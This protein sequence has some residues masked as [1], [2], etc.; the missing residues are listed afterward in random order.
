[1]A[2]DGHRLVGGVLPLD[3]VDSG[4][5]DLAGRLAELV[6]RVDVAVR[7][8]AGARPLAA[9]ADAIADAADALTA[10]AD[11]DAWQRAQLAGLLADV[12]TDE[13]TGRGPAAAGIALDLEEVRA[14]LADRL[15]GRP[16]RANFRTGHLTMCTLVPMRSVPHRVVCLLGLDDGAFPR[17]TAPDGDDVI[18]RAPCVGDHDPRSED[19]QLL[20]DAVLAATETVIVTYSGRDERTNE[21]RP[22]AVPLGE[23]L[24]VIDATVRADDGGPPAAPAASCNSTRCSPSTGRNFTAGALGPARPWSFDRIALAGA[25]AA[26]RPRVP[27]PPLLTGRLPPAPAEIVELDD[28]V[29]FVGHPVRAF[30]RQRLGVSVARGSTTRPPTRWP[31]SWTTSSAGVWASGCWRHC[32]PASRRPTAGRPSWR[33]DCCRPAR[34][35][36]GSW[37][38]AALAADVARV[39]ARVA[40]E[41]T[42]PGSVQIDVDLSGGRSLVGTV[43]D[44]AGDLVRTATY[45]RIGPKQRLTA[46]VRLLAVAA[47][48]PD[49]PVRAVTVGRG[50]RRTVGEVGIPAVEPDRR[51]VTVLDRLVDLYGRGLC[52]P[53]PLFART[54]AAYAAARF[55]GRP[56]DDAARAQ[57]ESSGDWERE[58]REPEHKLVP[59]AGSCPSTACCRRRHRRPTRPAPGGRPTSRPAS[60]GWPGACGTTCS[61][62]SRRRPDERGAAGRSISAGRCRRGRWC[63]KPAPVPARPSPSPP[64][65]P[66]TSPRAPPSTACCW[67]R[68]P[69]WPPGSCASASVTA[70]SAPSRAWPGWPPAGAATGGRRRAAPAGRRGC[71]RGRAAPPAAGGRPLRLRRRHHRHHPRVLPAH[72]ER[73]RR[74]R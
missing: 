53:L 8:F 69:A 7:S 24:D 21:P 14:L 10:T 28:L 34:W 41:G 61:P 30:L 51:R 39:A 46:W 49:R 25:E 56:G 42:Q 68:S 20:L 27:V 11:Q 32:S 57:W 2:E 74:G 9:W 67:S 13:A 4:D 45:S 62:S 17:R 26:A 22:P 50:P 15:R 1:M 12:A 59:W 73:A 54:S 43:P 58:D 18:A 52:E 70:W 64:S 35:A 47:S 3:D 33:G 36:C 31:S 23:L 37:T 5:I 60:A 66:A 55:R 16:T 40:G 72:P 44:V 29:R 71:R 38:D 48:Y 6:D 63:S 19:R 65:P